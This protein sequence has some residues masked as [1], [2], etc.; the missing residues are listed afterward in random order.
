MSPA[1]PFRNLKLKDG[2]VDTVE[3]ENGLCTA[4]LVLDNLSTGKNL[5][6]GQQER[7]RAEPD[8]RRKPDGD[9]PGEGYK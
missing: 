6:F 7:F 8:P 2:A 9:D 3:T 1:T 4:T 5:R